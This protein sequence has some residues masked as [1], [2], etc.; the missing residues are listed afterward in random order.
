MKKKKR[1]P[2]L[3]KGTA[4]S[5]LV[6][7]LAGGLLLVALGQASWAAPVQNPLSQTIP[8]RPTLPP[9][10]TVPGTVTPGGSDEDNDDSGP[11]WQG[12]PPVPNRVHVVV[13]VMPPALP[14][15]T[16][17]PTAVAAATTAAQAAGFP[18]C[19]LGVAVAHNPI[20][21]YDTR[22]LNLGWYVNYHTLD[23]SGA[24]AGMEFVHIVRVHQDKYGSC[25]DC[26]TQPYTYTMEPDADTLV[27]QVSANPGGTWLIGNEPDVRDWETGRQDEMVPEL[28]AQA[29][30]EV[31]RRIRGAD[32]TA[33]VA[34]GGV[35]QATPLRL[36]YLDRVWAQYESLYG[37]RLGD[38]VDIWNTHAYILREE[39]DSWGA[40]I[41][42]GLAETQGMLYEV[43][44]NANLDLFKEQI[45]RFRTWMRDRGERNKPLYI[46]EYGVIMPPY[47]ISLDRVK[48]FMGGSL[49]Y[50]LN[51]ADVELGYPA[52]GNRLVQR[53]LWYSLDD[54]AD[55][56]D[57]AEDYGGALFSSVTFGR[58]E[59]GDYLAAYI[60]D[61]RH[62]EANAPRVNLAVAEF[63]AIAPAELQASS[64][65][66]LTLRAAIQNR[67]NTVTRSGDG[68]EVR[69]WDGRPG[70]PQSRVVGR[71]I[72]RDIYGCA[73]TWVVEQPV[74]VEPGLAG[75]H[76]WFVDVEALPEE[77]SAKDNVASAQAALAGG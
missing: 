35:I 16:I 18:N 43:D 33:K 44:D 70:N 4:I 54:S 65:V 37:R 1:M 13:S 57:R 48:A 67:G 23:L 3:S 63:E 46:T 12:P 60:A 61:S 42:A 17:A 2:M 68:I 71:R 10:P 72:I 75:G 49:D 20:G 14:A 27:Q 76:L 52:D 5:L 21:T 31:S 66:T 73:Y 77:E 55:N 29:Y 62:V 26:Y 11:S 34:I 24:P 6:L 22:G 56:P 41:P 30:Y 38:D 58:L 45:S 69:F 32:P 40:D 74:A 47:Y 64:P 59:L 28:Y 39:K 51:V 53:C 7:M 36:K 19:R 25:R 9:S 15:P 50:M 8:P